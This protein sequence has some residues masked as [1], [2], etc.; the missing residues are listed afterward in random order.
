MHYNAKR[1]VKDGPLTAMSNI[2][3]ITQIF[4]A[5]TLTLFGMY[6]HSTT[7][8]SGSMFRVDGSRIIV[9]SL[10]NREWLGWDVVRDYSYAQT[11]EAVKQ[12]GDFSGFSLA[13]NVDAQLFVDA[14]V[15]LNACTATQPDWVPTCFTGEHPEWEPLVGES[16]LES[17]SSGSPGDHEAVK[18]LNWTG[19]AGILDVLV[20]DISPDTLS[21]GNLWTTIPDSDNFVGSESFGWLLFRERPATVPEPASILLVLVG[22]LALLMLRR[23]RRA[24]TLCP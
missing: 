2:R 14:L 17:R 15:G 5:V 3:N 24:A 21:K 11:V 1:S 9:D 10:N 7:I 20:H 18:F 12:G 16:Y 23:H 19:G 22:V 4:I 8:I 6:A 13:D